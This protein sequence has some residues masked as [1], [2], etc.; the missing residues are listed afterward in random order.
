MTTTTTKFVA[1]FAAL[2]LTAA[3]IL[4]MQY[5]AERHVARYLTAAESAQVQ[6]G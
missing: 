4:L 2:L 6:R 3:E 1:L 5:D